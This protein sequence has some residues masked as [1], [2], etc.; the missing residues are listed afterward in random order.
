[1]AMFYQQGPRQ[2]WRRHPIATGAGVVLTCWWLSN[3]WY[4][5][6][7]V[8]AVLATLVFV[9]HRRKVLARRDSGLRARADFE[10]GLMLAGDPRGTFGRYPPVQPGW[11]PDP[12]SPC[13]IR[14]FDGA[15]WTHFAKP[16]QTFGQ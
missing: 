12:Q 13:Q 1:M 14:Y 3:R 16:R 15:T 10:H 9:S 6:V 11:F 4:E 2:F 5:A 7:A 8:V